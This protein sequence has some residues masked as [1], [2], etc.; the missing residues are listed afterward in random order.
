MLFTKKNITWPKASGNR[1]LFFR[2]VKTRNGR[3]LRFASYLTGFEEQLPLIDHDLVRVGQGRPEREDVL[4]LEDFQW[5]SL[6]ALVHGH[7]VRAHAQ[8]QVLGKAAFL[9]LVGESQYQGQ[10][11]QRSEAPSPENTRQALA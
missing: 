8:P 11:A 2:V 1:I 7:G 5:S 6:P 9:A 10:T 4:V 3:F